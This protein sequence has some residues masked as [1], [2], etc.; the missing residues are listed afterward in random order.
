MKNL[1]QPSKV[2]L[3]KF[4]AV[5]EKKR[6]NF[7][8]A[9]NDA[10][11]VALQTDDTAIVFGEDVAFGGVF[12]C[13]VGLKEE[14]GKTRVFNTPLCEQGIAG[15]AIGYAAVRVNH[16]SLDAQTFSNRWV[17]LPSLKFNLRIIFILLLIN[18]SMRQQSI[19][20]DQGISSIV[21]V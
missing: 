17:G 15:F 7:F 11:R 20:I 6:M 5:V 16:S 14:F 13:S 10:M 9:I 21:V 3:R 19:D 4:S 1:H 12:R 2:L 8:T 18:L